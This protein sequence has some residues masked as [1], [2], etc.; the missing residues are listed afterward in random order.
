MLVLFLLRLLLHCSPLLRLG[1]LLH[2]VFVN[3]LL[4]LLGVHFG[5]VGVFSDLLC[6]L[7]LLD[8]L[9]FLPVILRFLLSSVVFHLVS[10]LVAIDFCIIF[11]LPLFSFVSNLIFLFFH[12]FHSLFL[13]FLLDF[14][15]EFGFLLLSHT[16]LARSVTPVR[17]V[18]RAN[19]IR[20]EQV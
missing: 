4:G 6:L 16:F 12:F 19:I 15:D 20:F 17:F 3:K 14:L 2:L 10:F 8:L 18:F 1:L 11:R 5:P 7:L 13:L 9:S